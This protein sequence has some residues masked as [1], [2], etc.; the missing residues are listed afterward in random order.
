MKIFFRTLIVTLCASAFV[1]CTLDVQDEFDFKPAIVDVDPFENQTAWQF[2]QDRT[3][4]SL[5]D[6][7]GRRSLN[8]I[9]GENLDYMAAAIRRVGYE[10]LYNQTANPNRTYFL[11]NNNAFTG[12]S[13]R[14]IGRITTGRNAPTTANVDDYF[15]NFNE[16]QLNR[17]KAILRYHI[18]DQFVDQIELFPTREINKLFPTLL[19]RVN[20][21]T[22]TLS[23]LP[24][25]ISILRDIRL[26]LL[27]N[28]QD[29]PLPPSALGQN[30]NETVRVHNFLFNNG[31][32]HFLNDTV[33][34][35]DYALYTDIDLDELDPLEE[36]AGE[37]E[38]L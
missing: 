22:L 9:N 31:I 28:R 11:L 34:F 7:R 35:Q 26:R 1:S 6:D 27:L 29:S 38:Q 16:E 37:S 8:R 12:G 17:L 10:E 30:F 24:S 20:E 19:R 32:G 18:V 4:N 21:N 36:L 5:L 3:S 15:A 33:R 25:Q 2:I 13:P 14:D 23:N